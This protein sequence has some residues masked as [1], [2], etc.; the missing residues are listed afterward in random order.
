MSYSRVSLAALRKTWTTAPPPDS[1]RRTASAA[2][3]PAPT[4]NSR[5]PLRRGAAGARCTTRGRSSPGTPRRRGAS[6]APRGEDEG[7]APQ[8]PPRPAVRH[9]DAP[10]PVPDLRGGRVPGDA[11]AGGEDLPR[12]A[13]V[14]GGARAARRPAAR[15]RRGRPREARQ[16]HP[17]DGGDG[18]HLPGHGVP[19]AA[20]GTAPDD[21]DGERSPCHVREGHG[22][23]RR[24]LAGA[25]RKFPL[26]ESAQ[27]QRAG[28]VANNNQIQDT[29]VVV[30]LLVALPLRSRKNCRIRLAD[31]V[32]WNRSSC[33]R[34]REGHACAPRPPGGAQGSGRRRVPRARSPSLSYLDAS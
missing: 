3:R 24:W 15:V 6:Q 13:R 18:Q 1:H 33:T 34:N 26:Q 32:T 7:A 30:V 16:R 29:I 27:R 8:R 17:P 22:G 25:D 19:G 2:L 5:A 21:G 14:V 10:E 28:S 4:T 11:G 12:V 23:G 20:G 9:R 31:R